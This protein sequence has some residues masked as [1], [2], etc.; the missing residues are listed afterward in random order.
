MIYFGA[1]FVLEKEE[2]ISSSQ[3]KKIQSL[4]APKLQDDTNIQTILYSIDETCLFSP[5]PQVCAAELD[6]FAQLLDNSYLLMNFDPDFLQGIFRI[7][8]KFISDE[9]VSRECLNIIAY[10]GFLDDKDCCA[11]LK[12][13]FLEVLLD[14]LSN[15]RFIDVI[16]QCLDCIHDTLFEHTV[17]CQELDAANICEGCIFVLEQALDSPEYFGNP[18]DRSINCLI[19]SSLMLISDLLSYFD[20]SPFFEKMLELFHR[21]SEINNIA[22][23]T[24]FV[25]FISTVSYYQNILPLIDKQFVEY[26]CSL[27]ELHK[28]E[29]TNLIFMAMNNLCLTSPDVCETVLESPIIRFKPDDLEF[30]LRIVKNYAKLLSTIFSSANERL[31]DLYILPKVEFFMNN[32]LMILNSNVFKAI[33]YGLLALCNFILINH[34]SILNY[35]F[36]KNLYLLEPLVEILSTTYYTLIEKVI[37]AIR[38]IIEYSTRIGKYQQVIDEYNEM[39]LFEQLDELESSPNGNRFGEMIDSL[40][41]YVRH[42]NE[43]V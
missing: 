5:D 4:I 17:T 22:V 25:R 11:M 23:Q 38:I 32:I 28:L 6:K 13:G 26:I 29:I 18:E 33:R 30:D 21:I 10:V 31:L 43:K 20:C 14:I 1:F 9:N 16:T 27:V 35:V 36:S 7:A 15:S 40:R 8:T 37:H 41:E 39:D 34:E 24:S 19:Q 42:L 12:T 3:D 2:E